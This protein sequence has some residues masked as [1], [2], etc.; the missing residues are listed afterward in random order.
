MLRG[1]DNEITVFY[2]MASLTGICYN[3]GAAFWVIGRTRM[4]ILLGMQKIDVAKN[5]FKLFYTITVGLGIKIGVI[6]Y[7]ARDALTSYFSSSN[8]EIANLFK[9]CLII[10]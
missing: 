9:T 6:V 5:Y 4:S 7:I 2:A 3:I 1:I 8:D 10:S